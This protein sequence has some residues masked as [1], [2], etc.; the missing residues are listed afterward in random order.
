MISRKY[1]IFAVFAAILSL[2]S[3]SGVK[4][5]CTTNCG[6]GGGGT[7]SLSLT[8]AAAPIVPPP[9]TSLLSFAVTINSVSLTP[10]SGGSA[11]NIPLNATTYSV[12]LTRLQSDSSFL[13]QVMSNVPAGTYNK[14]TVGVTSAVVTYCTASSGTAGC[15]FGSVAQFTSGASA[16]ATSAF[17]LTLT[18][19]E[20]AGLQVVFNIGNAITV[21][22]TTQVVSAVNLAAANVVTAVPLPPLASTL[23]TGQ[24]DYIEDVTG[25]VTAA[26]S[27]S[28]TVQT[29]TLGPI[30]SLL[31][32]S[33]ILSPNCVITNVTCSP[34]VGQIASIDATLN[35]DGTST[36][37]EYD[38]L[39]VTSV[40]V[41]EGIVT[42]V[43][44]SSTQFQIVTNDFIP[45]TS[46]SHIG[47]NLN[48][49]DPIQVTFTGTNPF[50]ID[51]KGLLPLATTT[52]KG[53]TSA[54]DILPGQTVAL[55]VTAFIPKSGTTPA[56][57]TVDFVVLR[58][59][60]VA[61][62]VFSTSPPTFL[63]QNLPLFFGQTTSSQVQLSSV[64]PF[65]YLDGYS[66]PSNITA[67][68]NV[69]VRALY[70]GVGATPAFT[71]AKVRKH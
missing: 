44:S 34:V 17:S 47:S 30:T 8:L 51:T 53:S 59:T 1:M 63:I 55:R 24:L 15:N 48:L 20:K 14:V 21:N 57:A 31:T 50:V 46:N 28:V 33:T 16:P 61:G 4:T 12:D 23:S 27:S 19:A 43:P 26:T 71:A 56:A 6:G 2:S 66:S 9:G 29:S 40:D 58:F 65:T 11:V 36:M 37:L 5:A 39:S 54:T 68:D 60:R 22:P 38:P 41:I 42:T 10:A 7:A 18:S 70:F 49:G 25:V 52:F 45:A 3:C 32:S 69:A 64:N 35:T 13:G 62:S 67:G